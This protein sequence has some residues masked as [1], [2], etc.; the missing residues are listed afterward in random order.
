MKNLF[1]LLLSMLFVA[2][3]STSQAQLWDKTLIQNQRLKI[4]KIILNDTIYQAQNTEQ[5]PYISFEDKKFYGFGGCNRFLGSY[6]LDDERLKIEN[7]SLVFTRMSCKNTMEFE[8][9]FFSHFKGDFTLV[10]DGDT[11]LLENGIVEIFLQ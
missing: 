4:E 2:C 11:L 9:L 8:N 6:E 7:D 10:K 1:F 3:S 5:T